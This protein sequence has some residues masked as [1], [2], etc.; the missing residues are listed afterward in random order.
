MISNISEKLFSYIGKV[1]N[2]KVIAI[3]YTFDK[4]NKKYNEIINYEID[5]NRNHYDGNRLAI[6]N[7][8]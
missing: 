6:F 3:R 8:A 4:I 1:R 2:Y 7:F 5:E